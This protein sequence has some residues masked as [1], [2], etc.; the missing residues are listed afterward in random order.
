M[1]AQLLRELREYLST[2]LQNGTI[3]LIRKGGDG[4]IDSQEN[5]RQI[6]H[7]LELYAISQQWPKNHGLQL[8]VAPPRHWYDFAVRGPNGLFLPVNVKVSTLKTSDN[9]SSK[10]GVFFAL[11]GID[12]KSVNIA[13]WERFCEGVAQHLGASP[14]TDYFFLIIG[15]NRPGDVFWTS[16]KRIEEL[17]P[18]GNNPPFQCCW[19][20]N[21]QHSQRT[22]EQAQQYILDVLRETFRLRARALHSFDQYLSSGPQRS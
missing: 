7:A 14:E 9:L 11:T 16:L 18:N 21:R 10:E 3:Q 5:E 15:K 1:H 22:T 8:E 12:P 20:R 17:V 6:S 13:T 2:A 19:A 4:R